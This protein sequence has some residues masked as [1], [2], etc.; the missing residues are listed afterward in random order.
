ME[1]LRSTWQE[2]LVDESWES[3][4]CGGP[5]GRVTATRRRMTSMV[6]ETL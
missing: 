5:G 3:D 2:T 4:P 6:L 1:S